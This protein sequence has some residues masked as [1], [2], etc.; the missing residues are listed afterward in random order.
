MRGARTDSL[1]TVRQPVC[2][3]MR[4]RAAG[5]L[6]VSQTEE[7][8]LLNSSTIGHFSGLERY[9]ED[10]S[11]RLRFLLRFFEEGTKDAGD[12]EEEDADEEE[13]EEEEEEES[14]T[15]AVSDRRRLVEE[16]GAAGAFEAYFVNAK[17]LK[18]VAIV[19]RR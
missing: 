15:A 17:K 13:E 8:K 2:D 10:G 19:V 14:L 5:I 11:L 4:T 18:E 7:K 16:E 3:P 6:W 9:F 1:A 12:D